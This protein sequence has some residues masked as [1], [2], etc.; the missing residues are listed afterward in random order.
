MTS[1]RAKLVILG[2]SIITSFIL[3]LAVVLVAKLVLSGIVSSIFLILVFFSTTSFFGT[4]LSLLS[5]QE[6]VLIYQHLIYL[7]YFLNCLN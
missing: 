6:D 2:I 4:S 7:L 5:P 3:A 1:R